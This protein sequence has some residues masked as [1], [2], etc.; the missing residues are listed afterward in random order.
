MHTFTVI[1]AGTQRDDNNFQQA[2]CKLTLQAKQEHVSSNESYA[3]VA[4]SC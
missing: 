1:L 2:A 4:L 3:V